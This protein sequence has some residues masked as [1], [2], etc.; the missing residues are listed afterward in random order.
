MHPLPSLKN[1]RLSIT[2]IDPTIKQGFNQWFWDQITKM[3]CGYLSWIDQSISVSN[4][5]N[6]IY[7]E[8]GHQRKTLLSFY[9]L[10]IASKGTWTIAIEGHET[11]KMRDVNKN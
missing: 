7:N 1:E 6:Q 2:I 3:G 10:P 11:G 5:G 4:V 8:G 9:T